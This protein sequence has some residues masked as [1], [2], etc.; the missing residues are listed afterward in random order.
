VRRPQSN[1]KLTPAD[2]E[3]IRE[4]TLFG[5]RNA[6]LSRAWGVTASTIHSARRGL[7]FPPVS[8]RPYTFAALQRFCLQA[9]VA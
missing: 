3:R 9:M 2:A 4:A 8:D 6:D 1:W 5:A 7:S